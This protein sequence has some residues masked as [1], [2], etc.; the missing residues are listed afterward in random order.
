MQ[1]I[2]K[3]AAIAVTK[4]IIPS[5]LKDQNPN[6]LAFINY[7]Y[8]WMSQN[9]YSLDLIEN[10]VEYRN[11]QETT[12][13]FMN[14]VLNELIDF[15]P[16]T[17][18]VNRALIA[19]KLK[20][21]YKAKGTL[22]SYDF[23]MNILFNDH[24][25][26]EWS[27]DKVF[28]PSSAIYT[29]NAYLSTYSDTAWGQN[30][31]G[32]QIL[33][34]YPTQA[35]AI[36]ESTTEIIVNNKIVNYLSIDPNSIVGT[37]SPYGLVQV[38]DNT[39][40]RSWI[41]ID[42][43]YSLTSLSTNTLSVSIINEPLIQYN[44][45]VVRQ[46]GSNF[47]GIV[48]TL[49]SRTI[50]NGTSNLIFTLNSITGTIGT[51]QIYFVE[52]A[53]EST[54]YN[55]G[56]YM[57]GV[58][59][60]SVTN[61]TLLNSGALYSVGD[62]INY[63]GGSGSEIALEVNAVSG[64]E[65]D[66]IY[67]A[68]GG[69]GYSPGMP[70]VVSPMDEGTGL[71]AVVTGIDGYG[72]AISPLLQL[73]N[74]H[75][76]NG[77]YSYAVG[78]VITLSDGVSLSSDY[79]T[80]LTVSSINN[81]LA[82]NRILVTE[83]GYG[84]QYA[85]IA[86]LDTTSNTLVS[87]FSAT[88]SINA[89][90]I[91]GITVNTYPTLADSTLSVLINGA[92][93]SASATVTS[94]SIT[95]IGS[96]VGGFN[97]FNPVIVVNSVQQPTRAAQFT[98][99]T[100][101]SGT[102]TGIAIVDGGAGYSSTVTLSIIEKFGAAATAKAITNNATSGPI[103]GFT[104]THY[105]TYSTLPTCF[106]APYYSTS[107]NGAGL[108]LDLK[109]KIKSVSVAN[110][111][112]YYKTI[113]TNNTYGLGQGAVFNT[114][115][116]NGVISAIAVG[117]GGSGYTKANVNVIGTGF[118]FSGLV[119]ISGG[120]VTGIAILNG[121]SGYSPGDSVVIYGDGT[122][123][124]ASLTV[125]NGVVT[126]VQVLN[127]GQ[128]YA[129]DSSFNYVMS[130]T[131]YPSAVPGSFNTTVTNGVITAVQ[132]VAGGTGYTQLTNDLQNQDYTYLLLQ[133]GSTKLAFTS[134][135]DVPYVS[136]G[137]QATIAYYIA[138]K[139]AIT[140]ADVDDGGSG[141]YATTEVTPLI[142]TVVSPTG[143][144]AAI[145]PVLEGGQIIATRVLDGGTGY[146]SS[147]TITVNG[148]GTG[149]SLTPIVYAG[150]VVDVI[151]NAPG[152]GYKYG[153]S[154]LV[155]GNGTGA[156][157]TPIVNTSITSISITTPGI[158]Y[159]NPTLTVTDSTGSGAILK[160]QLNG[161]GEFI[162]VTI[163]SGGTGYTAPH[164]TITDS[165][166]IGA[167]VAAAVQ[168]NIASVSITKPG[169]NYTSASVFVIGDG[170]GAAISLDFE[171][172]GS[173]Q[174]A[175]LTYSGTGYV[176]TPALGI[177]DISGFGAVTQVNILTG[178]TGYTIPPVL[179]LPTLYNGYTVIA[180]G[181]E[182]KCW[183][184]NIGKVAGV[185]FTKFGADWYELP[186][187]SFD[188]RAIMQSNQNFVLGETVSVQQF[189]TKP[190]DT[191]FYTLQQDGTSHII[192][193]IKVAPLAQQD[194]ISRILAEDYSQLDVEAQGFLQDE[195]YG[196]TNSAGV[197]VP[198]TDP[199]P[200]ATIANIDFGTGVLELDNAS[201][202]V[203][204]ISEDGTTYIIGEN[205]LNIVD[206]SSDEI[207]IGDILIGSVSKAQSP[208]LWFN[209]ADGVPTVSGAGITKLNR[210]NSAGVVSSP[211]SKI[212]DGGRIQDFAY[213]VKTGVPLATYQDIFT[214]V[215]HPAGYA[216]YGEVVDNTF[217]KVPPVSVPYSSTV[218]GGT[219]SSFY[220]T[221]NIKDGFYDSSQFHNKNFWYYNSLKSTFYTTQG[222]VFANY[223]FGNFDPASPTFI[224]THA[225]LMVLEPYVAQ[226]TQYLSG[227]AT[228]GSDTLTGM[229][230]LTG[231]NIGY[232]ITAY[233]VN[234][235][236]VF[237]ENRI[238]NQDLTYLLCQD[239]SYIDTNEVDVRVVSVTGTTI[240]ASKIANE[241]TTATIVV[242][243]TPT[244]GIG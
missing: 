106:N 95:A 105:G 79:P 167:A 18:S 54:S 184:N 233:D 87:G 55:I 76:R 173:I 185:D 78:D 162:G 170:S 81:T 133:D 1:G 223:T 44:G 143:N 169:T 136:A 224:T 124:S 214:Q 140:S 127:G 219:D 152:N 164:I 151:I 58:V 107:V 6:L 194:G 8:D 205:G 45:L 46:V 176:A 230:G 148:S 157:L 121:G 96:I 196:I 89:G 123:A 7:Y 174:N 147:D 40:N 86:L 112:Q 94:G 83:G 208:V 103:T 199:G 134:P 226:N 182:F 43:Y 160:A 166:G 64:G 9:G 101:T 217:I 144:N 213:V 13:Q 201:N 70:I 4:S 216:M 181:A 69:Y 12:T 92:G 207:A 149:A 27:A 193:D 90:M 210:T 188:L 115:I 30:V 172:N 234:N 195:Y 20:D 50:L 225:P 56:S 49:T 85:N 227:T 110:G 190:V 42:T 19:V 21:F 14:L 203:N 104:I 47:R 221:L 71:S 243:N 34:T 52:A 16:A 189:P 192:I 231:I 37:F 117:T 74:F 135:Y 142:I 126:A 102:I 84:Y 118:G 26:I 108:I 158:S 62:T 218:S 91:S 137:S 15:I 35:S 114:V 138:G 165:T 154:L 59:S 236:S 100:N 68:D 2:V 237:R 98:I 139:G 232:R 61:I 63:I 41:Y 191:S 180:S 23:L 48:T 215:V 125:A 10:M 159:T 17:S 122:G 53:V 187:I 238:E 202:T 93:A 113:T 197:L 146:T 73:D 220:A 141:Y 244:P 38:L 211:L 204:I 129:Y 155:L 128:N 183:G 116:S 132:V 111:G 186:K 130:P 24:V 179:S 66:T 28:R 153:T 75:I 198:Y 72:A 25:Q 31:V 77:G 212:Q 11:V 33:Q 171:L 209:R 200:S 178:G 241:T 177:T 175:T 163:L 168:R 206:Q 145:L 240:Q 229:S 57:M 39:I 242:E 80:T 5:Y 60:P 32:S 97:Y 67:I 239:G 235:F 131:E 222:S 156:A 36:I 109:Y 65:V 119:S 29:N 228:L 22:P 150:K 3:P 51:G 161:L 99:T 120:V 88:A 82:L